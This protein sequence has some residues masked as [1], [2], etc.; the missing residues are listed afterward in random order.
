MKKTTPVLFLKS[1]EFLS[2]Q[3]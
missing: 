3:S 2:V 1:Q